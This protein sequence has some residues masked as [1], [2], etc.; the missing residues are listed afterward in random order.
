MNT[1]ELKTK[2]SVNEEF[3]EDLTAKSWQEIENLQNQINLIDTNSSDAMKVQQ[4]LKNLLT[5]YYVFAG[6]LENINIS[7]N[8]TDI[9]HEPSFLEINPE[10]NENDLD[11]DTFIKT[12]H[13]KDEGTFEPFEYFVDFDE[14][15]GQPLTDDDLYF[16]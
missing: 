3:I 2:I 11:D 5:S 16:K 13:T 4:L 9:P 15:V 7:C 10:I 14:P 6:S 1:Q 8:N 12:P